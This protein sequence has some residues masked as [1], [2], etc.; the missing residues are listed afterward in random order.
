MNQYGDYRDC[1]ATFGWSLLYRI[2]NHFRLFRRSH[3]IVM[4]NNHLQ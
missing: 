4:D 1:P 3:R 2:K